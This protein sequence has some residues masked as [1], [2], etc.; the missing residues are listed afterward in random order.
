M[1]TDNAYQAESLQ[2]STTASGKLTPCLDPW[3]QTLLLLDRLCS[4]QPCEESPNPAER[5][6]EEPLPHVEGARVKRCRRAHK[7]DTGCEPGCPAA[8]TLLERLSC[9]SVALRW[10][11]AT[12]HYGYQIWVCGKACRSGTC[13]LTGKAIHRGDDIYRPQTRTRFVPLNVNA[14]IHLSAFL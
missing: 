6:P 10:C 13:V 3:S 5:A 7:S 2:T 4:Q 12:C 14:M 1:N 9:R 11:S 8:I